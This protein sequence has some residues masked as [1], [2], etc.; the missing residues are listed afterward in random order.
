[1]D[2]GLL[3]DV[4]NHCGG[5]VNAACTLLAE[6]GIVRQAPAAHFQLVASSHSLADA[7][8]TAAAASP[9]LLVDSPCPF[10]E[11]DRVAGAGGGSASMGKGGGSGSS[12]SSSNSTCVDEAGLDLEQ[13]AEFEHEYQ[14]M[15]REGKDLA[16]GV[17]VEQWVVLGGVAGRACV[18]G[19][20]SFLPR[21]TCVAHASLTSSVAAV[22]VVTNECEGRLTVHGHH[23]DTTTIH[24]GAS[25]V[26]GLL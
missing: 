24:V 2:R 15:L 1:M 20:R 21:L 7:A 26:R 17:L 8:R 18:R 14:Q 12:S 6:L 3:Q 19:F 16:P 5:D 4:L 10:E 23:N 22:L 25:L 9:Q 11:G 13:D